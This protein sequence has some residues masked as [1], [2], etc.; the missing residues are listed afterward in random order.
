MMNKILSKVLTNLEEAERLLH[1]KV[2]FDAYTDSK[3]T[4]ST[5]YFW[6]TFEQC[7]RLQKFILKTIKIDLCRHFIVFKYFLKYPQ[8]Y[9]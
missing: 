5:Q 7:I 9:F 2:L 3:Y 1:I 6:L 4:D 8:T